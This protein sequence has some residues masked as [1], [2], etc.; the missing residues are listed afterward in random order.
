MEQE[1][2]IR[3]YLGYCPKCKQNLIWQM[4]DQDGED[5]QGNLVLAEAGHQ[6]HI[7]VCEGRIDQDAS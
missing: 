4:R 2:P 6:A 3:G 1:R 5:R 7:A